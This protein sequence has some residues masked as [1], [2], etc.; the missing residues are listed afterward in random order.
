MAT[1]ESQ[2]G[3]FVRRHIPLVTVGGLLVAWLSLY[4]V[5]KS[6][7]DAKFA[8]KDEILEMRQDIREIRNAVI[9]EGR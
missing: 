5:T 7:A 2:I 9:K 3:D 8:R 6:E 1:I 4:F